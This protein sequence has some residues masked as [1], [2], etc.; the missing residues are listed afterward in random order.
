MNADKTMMLIRVHL[1]SSAF[2]S[3][4]KRFFTTSHGR[5]AAIFEE[6]FCQSPDEFAGRYR[7]E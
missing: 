6:G 2:I 1:R 5:A 3:G 4:H 7:L